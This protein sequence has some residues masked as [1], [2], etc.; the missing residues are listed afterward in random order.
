M[1]I[2]EQI[3]MRLVPTLD[4]ITHTRAGLFFL[5]QAFKGN[6]CS[7][8]AA[9][10]HTGYKSG[11][12]VI[13]ATKEMYLLDFLFNPYLKLVFK[14]VIIKSTYSNKLFTAEENIH[15]TKISGMFYRYISHQPSL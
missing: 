8:L 14:I 1:L 4:H 13:N 6:V 11:V 5:I 12:G 15:Y 9:W 7:L 3:S 2:F 10:L